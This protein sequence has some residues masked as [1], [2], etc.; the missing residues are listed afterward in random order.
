MALQ[1]KRVQVAPEPHSHQLH[2]TEVFSGP[3]EGRN[4][5]MVDGVDPLVQVAVLV[6]SYV[7]EVLGVK[8]K[9]AVESRNLLCQEVQNH[10]GTDEDEIAGEGKHECEERELW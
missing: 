7:P 8:D 5:V 2:S 9:Q 10:K 6:V 4:V 1:K 3:G